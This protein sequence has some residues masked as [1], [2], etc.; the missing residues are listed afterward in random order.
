MSD[1]TAKKRSV[2]LPED[3]KNP[4]NH[5]TLNDIKRGMV[6][7][8]IPVYNAFDEA[9][10]C[11]R[12]VVKHSKGLDRIFVIDD[13]SPSGDFASFL[14][15]RL[16]ETELSTLQLERNNENIGYLRT[17]NKYIQVCS[18][19]D[20]ILLNSDT[21]VTNRFAEKLKRAAYSRENIGSVTPLT[22][23]GTICSIP[24]F[25]ISN[26]LPPGLSVEDLGELVEKRAVPAYP[27]LPTCIGFCTYIPR[28][29][30][31][32]IGLFDE[33]SFENGYG[34]ENDFSC[35]LQAEGLLD[36]LDDATFV[37]H[38]GEQSFSQEKPRLVEKNSLALSKKHPHYF[39]RVA[40][41]CGKNSLVDVRNRI[42]DTLLERDNGGKPRVLHI[43]H[44]GPHVDRGEGLGGTELHVKML[45]ENSPSVAHWSLVP[46]KGRCYFLTAHFPGG[47]REFVFDLSKVTLESVIRPEYFDVIH[48]HHSRFIDHHELSNALIR[49]GNFAVSFHDF[50]QV[51][52]RF[53]LMTPFRQV[54][55]GQECTSQC[56][57]D[58]EYI[59]GYREESRRLL[60]AARELFCFSQS[61][62]KLVEGVLNEQFSWTEI[63]HGVVGSRSSS[64]GNIS[65]WMTQRHQNYLSKKEG[66]PSPSRP[67]KICFVG[68]IPQHKGSL[69]IDELL[70]CRSL[71]DGL[72]I[73]WHVIGKLFLK[74]DGR[75]VQ[76]GGYSPGELPEK[77]VELDPDLVMILSICPETYCMTL[78]ESWKAGIPCV[79]SPFGAPPE[80]VVR[81]GA[82]WVLNDMSPE[83]IL[84][85]LGNIASNWEDDYLSKLDAVQ[86]RV[87]LCSIEEEA[88]QYDK[89]YCQVVSEL[90]TSS[91]FE[92]LTHFLREFGMSTVPPPRWYERAIG[93]MV[94]LAV[95]L[96]D[97]FHI[98]PA[99][100]K[101]VTS[102]V[103]I[104]LLE[105]MKRVRS[106]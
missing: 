64:P 10:S 56:G 68:T 95:Y 102:L 52:P 53:H 18:P 17:C 5:Q 22:N 54:C 72:P 90:G 46:L 60:K 94:N 6:C 91:S 41:W 15:E 98:R 28:R 81:S 36:I 57:Y 34:E 40:K 105:K 32:A 92:S 21:V 8:I 11:V 27:E 3:H 26:E 76:H 24:R 51:C 4:K 83:G 37:Y 49:H 86:N 42:L 35:R 16:S 59:S 74:E 70:S 50:V 20:V 69:I 12:S 77:L 101:F 65:N 55:S 99:V 43:V 29:T 80:R 79:V 31:E 2:S 58:S 87:D 82:G 33:V 25:G 85:Q 93:S 48:L 103:P 78:D 106:C 9:L 84:R 7:A 19:G 30:F 71:Q 66:F 47:E 61:T 73:E 13:G 1:N 67:L 44:N 104:P 23:N 96:L 88:E 75:F 14:K 45:M 100:Q 38:R 89:R 39:D 62:R 97:A 63:P